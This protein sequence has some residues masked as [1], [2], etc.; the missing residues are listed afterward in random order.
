[1]NF[2]S[3][4]TSI[5]ELKQTTANLRV[6]PTP[7]SKGYEEKYCVIGAGAA[8]LA[9]SKYL[10]VAGIP[11]DTIELGSEV[12]GLWDYSRSD[13][14]MYKNTHLIGHKLTQ[15]YTD[16]PMPQSYPE[17]P[18]HR[19]VFNYLRDYAKHFKLYDNIQFDTAVER[20][21]K[22]GDYWQVTLSTGETRR[23]RGVLIASGYHNK[24]NLPS[25]P[26]KFD[27]EI[28]H[29]KDYDNPEQLRNKRVLIVGGGQSAMD[30]V[31]ES[32]ISAEQTFHSTRRGFLCMPKFL[33]GLPPEMVL[34]NTP[35]MNRIPAQEHMKV[36]SKL[37]PIMLLLQGVNLK[38]LGIPLNCE[39]HG[40]IVP[41]SDQQ[42]YRYY[43]HGDVIHKSNIKAL[44][45]DRVLFEDGTEEMIDVIVYATGYRVEFPFIAQ[46][47]LNWS[48][49]V[50][51]PNLF[52]NVFHPEENNLFVIGM[53]HPTG[54]H[55]KVFESQSE[56]VASYIQAQAGSKPRALR[57]FET[58]KAKA[59]PRI[60]QITTSS[61]S[62]HTLVIDKLSY[63]RQA[64]KLAQR[65]SV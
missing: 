19:L 4:L 5:A 41:N 42:I 17:Y 35:I 30:I 16:F 2:E 40:V 51:H 25:F 23:Y 52:L 63:M 1:M 36:M 58:L 28:L 43:T 20:L 31:V 10:K 55:W 54:S 24:P 32:A 11:F 62:T 49:K 34:N 13:S 45:G 8:G 15:P 26:G 38:K 22:A 61:K 60:N 29:A 27:G 33:F 56:L 48:E 50:A 37:M 64:K 44:N 12:G 57:K 18:G 6:A 53:I 7:A 47:N 39:S 14:P 59:D 21:E 65:L 9:A 46:G 3:S